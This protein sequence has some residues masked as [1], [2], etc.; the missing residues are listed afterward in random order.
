MSTSTSRPADPLL[1]KLQHRAGTPALVLWAPSEV[2]PV[3]AAW[4]AEGVTVHRRM[5]G[6]SAFVLAF[7]RSCAEITER[8]PKVARALGGDDPVLWMAYPKK[9]SKRY[10]S[11][12]GRDDSWQALGDLGF[13]P[14]RQV[15]VDEDW[16]ALRFRRV[17]KVAKLTRSRALSSDGKARLAV[18][19]DPGVDRWLAARDESRRSSLRTVHDLIRATAPELAPRVEGASV[20]YGP[21]HYVYDTGRQGDSHRIIL[22]DNARYVS[23]YVL[24]GDERGYY[25]EQLADR[26]GK[27]ACGKSC[28]RFKK[29]EDLD[30]GGLRELVRLAADQH[31]SEAA[32]G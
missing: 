16:S 1:R 13:E 12:V 8:A 10:R 23:L 5:R 11:D 17:A 30:L 4:E 6:G 29:V 25:A 7:V 18:R 27:A 19:D 26:L 20:N 31:A 24:A 14:V 21:F 9:S 2:E 32:S 15:A 22:R 3:L 28:V